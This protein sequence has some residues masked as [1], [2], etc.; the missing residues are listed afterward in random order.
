[1]AHKFRV[2]NMVK[3]PYICSKFLN[4]GYLYISIKWFKKQ[5]HSWLIKL[6]FFLEN[7]RLM[8]FAENEH[9]DNKFILKLIQEWKNRLWK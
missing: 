7:R 2:C 9:F 5:H 8:N 1:M 6:A 4:M 3:I